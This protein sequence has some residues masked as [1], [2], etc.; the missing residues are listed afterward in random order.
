MPVVDA[1]VINAG[2]MSHAPPEVLAGMDIGQ[3]QLRFQ[4]V[5]ASLLCQQKIWTEQTAASD[6]WTEQSVS[7]ETWTEAA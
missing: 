3:A 5:D 2:C 4:W 6:I 7:S 1:T